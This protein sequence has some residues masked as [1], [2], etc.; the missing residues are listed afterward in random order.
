MEVLVAA[1]APTGSWE[2]SDAAADQPP[3]PPP[4]PYDEEGIESVFRI[5]EQFFLS[6]FAEGWRVADTR[7]PVRTELREL[8]PI[9]PAASPLYLFRSTVAL[10]D[11]PVS[12]AMRRTVAALRRPAWNEFV[13]E[14]TTLHELR[15]A[16]GDADGLGGVEVLLQRANYFGYELLTQ[17]I[18]ATRRLSD[19]SGLIVKVSA[20]LKD[21]VW[22]PHN[23][24]KRFKSINGGHVAALPAGGSQVTL[25]HGSGRFFWQNLPPQ[26][27]CELMAPM[28]TMMGLRGARSLLSGYAESRGIPFRGAGGQPRALSFA[29]GSA[30]F[31]LGGTPSSDAGFTLL[32]LDRAVVDP[33][34]GA[35]EME[36][37]PGAPWGPAAPGPSPSPPSASRGP[38]PP[39]ARDVFYHLL[40][41]EHPSDRSPASP[42]G[43]DEQGWSP[44]SA[45]AVGGG[46]VGGG[47]PCGN[48]SRSSSSSSPRAGG[49]AGAHGAPG[50]GAGAGAG[51]VPRQQLSVEAPEIEEPRLLPRVEE[52]IR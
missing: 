39:A 2:H 7:G 29:S 15:R 19:G 18:V 43:S 16:A 34:G 30:S 28:L 25:F 44:G 20:E 23:F 12:F 45:V 31:A 35:G 24:D 42:S 50:A 22:T 9:A 14:E 46:G 36:Y 11:V 27:C 17:M 4:P 26:R 1:Q 37:P 32:S 41:L 52:A 48:S 5:F 51:G 49:G 47:V 40:G 13:L 10:P 21:G 8:P 3:S 6:P 33:D 38:P